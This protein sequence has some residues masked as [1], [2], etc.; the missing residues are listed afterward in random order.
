MKLLSSNQF[1]GVVKPFWLDHYYFFIIWMFNSAFVWLLSNIIVGDFT[2]WNCHLLIHALW[3]KKTTALAKCSTFMG[4][5]CVNFAR[6]KLQGVNTRVF[7]QYRPGPANSI[8]WFIFY[9]VLFVLEERHHL[10]PFYNEPLLGEWNPIDNSRKKSINLKNF[11][12][13]GYWYQF[14]VA[15]VNSNGTRG[16]ST[17]SDGF[18]LAGRELTKFFLFF[19]HESKKNVLTVAPEPPRNSN[20]FF[21]RFFSPTSGYLEKTRGNG[22]RFNDVNG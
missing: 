21:S 6:N 5:K 8:D 12:K 14:R 10:G 18:K 20:R 2:L 11:I 15:A 22:G 19:C 17:E 4:K 16:F 7:F 9:R 13:P 3:K 1:T